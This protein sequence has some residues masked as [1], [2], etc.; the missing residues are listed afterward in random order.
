MFTFFKSLPVSTLESPTVV[1]VVGVGKTF[2]RVLFTCF[3]GFP[4][5]LERPIFITIGFD[6]ILFTWKNYTQVSHNNL[7]CTLFSG[8][9]REVTLLIM[10]HYKHTD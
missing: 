1:V 10:M 9:R 2:I 3:D 8:M 4:G 7:S 5:N 6:Y